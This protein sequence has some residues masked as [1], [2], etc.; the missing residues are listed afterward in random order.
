MARN[1]V[2]EQFWSIC[3]AAGFLLA[4]LGIA[5]PMLGLERRRDRWGCLVIAGSGEHDMLLIVDR[6]TFVKAARARR[7]EAVGE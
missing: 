7:L 5:V 4:D 6:R 3:C 1:E 2:G